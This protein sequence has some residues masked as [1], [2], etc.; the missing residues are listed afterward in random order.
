MPFL[1]RRN[2]L[3]SALAAPVVA[4]GGGTQAAGLPMSAPVAVGRVGLRAQDA[5]GLADW[6]QANV[7]L[8]RMGTDGAVIRMGAGS[9]VLLEI[10]G[11]PALRRDSTAEAGL[12]HTAFLLPSRKALA[13]WASYAIDRQ[14][15]VDGASDHLVSE[16]IY[17]TDPEG[18]GVEIYADRD[19]AGWQW[20]AGQVAMGTEAL[21]VENLL[22]ELGL[23]P[24]FWTGAP[25][26]TVVG[27]VHLR[28]GDAAQAAQWWNDALGFQTVRAR[29]GAAFV[30]TGGYHHHVGLNHWQSEGAG[31]RPAG[32][33][34]LAH[35]E[36]LS[37]NAPAAQV[38]QDPW[39]TEIRLVPV[40]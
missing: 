34:G 40:A 10:L 30:S 23:T 9:R 24:Q 14:I 36:L 27:H 20:S 3:S 17:L 16:A 32:H 22:G 39:G 2:L 18:N 8:R 7:G 15:P 13:L 35:V 6:Y 1:T 11:D 26:G 37:R 12:Y 21:D 25:D 5:E 33:T 19:A 28:V 4:L 31:N 38:L 29:G